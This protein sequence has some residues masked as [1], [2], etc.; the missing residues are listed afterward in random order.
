MDEELI[1]MLSNH[2][3]TIM[4]LPFE[5]QRIDC[6]WIYKVKYDNL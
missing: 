5:K 1:A 4:P 3:C 6:H 2:T